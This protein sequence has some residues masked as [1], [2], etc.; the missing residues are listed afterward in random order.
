MDKWSF[1]HKDDA[2]ST[3]W[4]HGIMLAQYRKAHKILGFWGK[5]MLWL[6]GKL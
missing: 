1:Y 3:D 5:F 4:Q 6:K 2:Y